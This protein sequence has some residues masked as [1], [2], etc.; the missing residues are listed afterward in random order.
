MSVCVYTP[1]RKNTSAAAEL[2]EF[3][4]LKKIKEN[5]ISN[6]QPVYALICS[7]IKDFIWAQDHNFEGLDD[8]F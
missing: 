3:R 8:V 2:S 6:E 7:S 5:Q 1:G 4:K